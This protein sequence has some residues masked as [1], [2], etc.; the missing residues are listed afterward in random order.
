MSCLPITQRLNGPLGLRELG[1][2]PHEVRVDQLVALTN[3]GGAHNGA[4]L[5]ERHFQRPEAANDLCCGDLVG[6]VAAVAGSAININGREQPDLVVVTQHLH[7]QLRR[8]GEVPDRQQR[9]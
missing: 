4:D 8:T 7:A 5:I 3:V 1:F 2:Q 9:W 6:A